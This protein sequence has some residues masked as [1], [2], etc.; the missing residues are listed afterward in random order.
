MT[1]FVFSMIFCLSLKSVP[2]LNLPWF[3]LMFLPNRGQPLK[4]S[5]VLCVW[6]LLT[7][8]F[9]SPV[10]L[11]FQALWVFLA[12]LIGSAT[13]TYWGHT[14]HP[15]HAVLWVS[16]GAAAPSTEGNTLLE[17][18]QDRVRQIG[19]EAMEDGDDNDVRLHGGLTLRQHVS[20]AD[21]EPTERETDMTLLS[22]SCSE[23]SVKQLWYLCW[24]K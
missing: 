5:C 4:T 1:S 10:S 20:S 19:R 17:T 13:L 14:I 21:P 2:F 9:S 6:L 18:K 12:F 3:F 23:G 11:L 16:S 8:F 7:S 22:N 15:P 24:Q